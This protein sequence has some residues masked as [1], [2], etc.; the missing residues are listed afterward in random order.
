[1]TDKTNPKRYTFYIEF[2]TYDDKGNAE[3]QR[4]TW[5]CLSMRQA[6]EMNRRTDSNY[7][8]VHSGVDVVRFGWEET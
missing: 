4:L 5:T 7:S 2:N 3:P 8:R 6:E 1:M